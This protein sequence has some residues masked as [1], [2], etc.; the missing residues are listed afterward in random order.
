MFDKSESSCNEGASSESSFSE[1]GFGRFLDA[2]GL[3]FNVVCDI[4][5]EVIL[6]SAAFFIFGA[7][8]AAFG[9]ALTAFA[10]GLENDSQLS[11]I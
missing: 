11:S 7:A 6:G 2:V 8:F 1:S 10:F 9:A 3:V 5:F 4:V